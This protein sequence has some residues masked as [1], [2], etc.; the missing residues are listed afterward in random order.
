MVKARRARQAASSSTS[1]RVRRAVGG[2]R[3]LGRRRAHVYRHQRARAAV[4]GGGG[5]QRRRA[6]AADRH[7]HRQPRDRRADQHL[8]RPLGQHVDARRRLDPAL[9][10]DQSGGA[11]PAH[12]GVPSGRGAVLP[13]DGVHGRLHPDP[14]LRP[15]RRARRRQRWTRILPPY[16]AAP[17]ARSRRA[18]SASARWSGRKRSPR[19]AISRTTSSCAPSS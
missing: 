17:G 5:L 14:C 11:R 13:G 10:R 19:C 1:S 9:C 2:D 6:R 16:R 7:D 12:P 3:R 8:E 18:R 4:H 15:D